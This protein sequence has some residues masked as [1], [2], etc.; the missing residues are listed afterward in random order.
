MSTQ[1]F[2][3]NIPQQFTIGT[4]VRV[5]IYFFR[6]TSL[7]RLRSTSAEKHELYGVEETGE[8]HSGWSGVGAIIESYQVSR[9]S[10]NP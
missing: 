8:S 2:Y 9:E 10:I 3:F 4:P 7:E 5:F 6:V 1:G